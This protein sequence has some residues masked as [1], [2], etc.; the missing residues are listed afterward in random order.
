MLT[1]ES[2]WTETSWDVLTG[3]ERVA[4][5]IVEAWLADNPHEVSSELELWIA[6]NRQRDVVD[7]NWDKRWQ[8]EL[9]AVPA[10]AEALKRGP[11]ELFERAGLTKFQAMAMRE[12]AGGKT[13]KEIAFANGITADAASSR[14]HEARQKLLA[15][16]VTP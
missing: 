6:D 1:P 16:S 4:H 15:L 12:T 7:R 2:E 9:A 13:P 11:E 3:Q 10:I 8:V 5:A 14:I